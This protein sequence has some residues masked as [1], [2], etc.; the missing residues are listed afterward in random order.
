[1]DASFIQERMV[2]I[3]EQIVL[4]EETMTKLAVNPRASYSIDTGQ[5]KETVTV[6]SLPMLENMLERLWS[7][8]QY[9]SDLV[10]GTGDPSYA[11]PGF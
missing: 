11:A 4:I 8:Y 5:H 6:Q 9:Y 2:V 7:R 1:M 10:N 3:K